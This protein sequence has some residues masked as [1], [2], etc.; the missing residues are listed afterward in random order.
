MT[1]KN[2]RSPELKDLTEKARSAKKAAE[3]PD[4]GER[5]K[6][7]AKLL[8]QEALGEKLR[9]QRVPD[10]VAKPRSKV[11]AKLDK[12]LED[13]F[14]GSDPVSFVEAAGL[15]KEDEGLSTVRS[16]DPKKK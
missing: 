13:S 15:R 1:G 14:P 2:A 3:A 6:A 16:K 9:S 8:E 5:E 12:A 10:R 4:A 11:D 7:D